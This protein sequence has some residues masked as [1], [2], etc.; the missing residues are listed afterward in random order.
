MLEF[1]PYPSSVIHCYADPGVLDT[2]RAPEG[3]M[4]FRIA[5]GELICVSAHGAARPV[6]D[7]LSVQASADPHALLL[8]RSDAWAVFT[9]AG[10]QRV[11]AFSRLCANPLPPPP[12]LL[13][14]AI[15]GVAARAIVL[16]DR[17]H[18]LVSSVVG[19]HLRQRIIDACHDLEPRESP[20]LSAAV[21]TPVS[22]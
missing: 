14:G 13:Q 10:S 17:I 22:T 20:S 7:A 11:A 3:A 5:R 6:L 19:D 8:D 4:V 1:A 9:L 12:A 21:E 15:A 16:P 2:L 18:M